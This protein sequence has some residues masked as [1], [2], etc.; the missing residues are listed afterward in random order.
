MPVCQSFSCFLFQSTPELP[1]ILEAEQEDGEELEVPTNHDEYNQ[2]LEMREEFWPSCK[3][4]KRGNDLY[5]CFCSGY[6]RPVTR[7]DHCSCR[8]EMGPYLN[9]RASRASISHFYSC[10]DCS[11]NNSNVDCTWNAWSSWGSCSKTCGGGNKI[12]SRTQNGPYRG[13]QECSGSPTSSTS[14]Q[15]N[16]CP[17]SGLSGKLTKQLFPCYPLMMLSNRVVVKVCR[18]L[19]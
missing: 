1:T 15:T 17:D 12:R 3:C 6:G 2:E 16:R 11:C 9:T 8:T 7:I 18:I 14:C 19:T 10:R 13:G 5:S 4:A